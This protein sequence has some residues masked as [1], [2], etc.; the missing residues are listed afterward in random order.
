MAAFRATDH[1]GDVTGTVAPSCSGITM[2]VDLWADFMRLRTEFLA[3]PTAAR[4]TAAVAAFRCWARGFCPAAAIEISRIL[5]RRFTA[6]R[7]LTSISMRPM[8]IW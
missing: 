1:A 4:Q 8:G 2:H 7:A 6:H 3:E 5:D